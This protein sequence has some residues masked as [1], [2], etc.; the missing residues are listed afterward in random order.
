MDDVGPLAT[1]ARAQAAQ[2]V[3]VLRRL[4][5][6]PQA[7][8][9][10]EAVAAPVEVLAYRVPGLGGGR[11]VH[12]RGRPQGHLVAAPGEGTGELVIVRARVSGR[13]DKRHAEGTAD[14]SLLQWG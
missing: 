7:G 11:S 14:Q 9:H 8:A 6:G 4:C 3:E 5:N 12:E 13:V 10:I 2:V 1:Q